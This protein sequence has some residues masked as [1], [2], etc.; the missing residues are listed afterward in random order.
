MLMS[1]NEVSGTIVDSAI[2][3]HKAL[4]PGLLESVY[5]LVLMHDLVERGFRVRSKEPIPL[6]YESLQIDKAFEADLIVEEQVIVEIKSVETL[7][8]V[9]SKQLL[10]YLKL[11]NLHL[12]LLLNFNAAYLKDGIIRLVNQLPEA[13]K[14]ASG[15]PLL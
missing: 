10:T 13:N 7:L 9:H 5:H 12:G 15:V 2:K 6:R 4:G 1:P 3:I 11:T 8:P 14:L